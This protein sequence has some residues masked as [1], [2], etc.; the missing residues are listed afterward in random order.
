[1]AQFIEFKTIPKR[2]KE[3]GITIDLLH[4]VQM[5]GKLSPVQ[6]MKNENPVKTVP[7]QNGTMFFIMVKDGEYLR[8]TDN[9]TFIKEKRKSVII[10]RARYLLNYLQEEIDSHVENEITRI[11]KNID[12]EFKQ[13]SY[14]FKQLCE[15]ADYE[16]GSFLRILHEGSGYGD[17]PPSVIQARKF[18][19][20]NDR[21]AYQRYIK[22]LSNAH[23]IGDYDTLYHVFN[24]KRLPLIASFDTSNFNEMYVLKKLF[25]KENIPIIAEELEADSIRVIARINIEKKYAFFK[26]IKE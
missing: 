6:L 24:N 22:S 3:E 10:G 20:E 12:K 2:I 17:L 8:C 4:Q 23:A 14:T 21:E 1:M 11:K 16:P 19:E 13:L 26:N 9:K 5:H 7:T 15:S 18:F 25:S